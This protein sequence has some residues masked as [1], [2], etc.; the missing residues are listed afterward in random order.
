LFLDGT[1]AL[2]KIEDD[3]LQQGALAGSTLAS[4]P[5]RLQ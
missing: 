4:T 5:E 2:Y 1:D 3:A